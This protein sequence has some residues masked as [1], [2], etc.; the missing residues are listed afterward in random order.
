MSSLKKLLQWDEKFSREMILDEKHRLPRLFLQFISHS[1]DSWYW[2]V[3]LVLVWAFSK[4]Q[5]RQMALFLAF[6]LGLLAVFVLGVKFLVRRARP[7]GEW[8][9]IYR[10]T[11]PHS[12]PSGHAARAMA[13]A[14]ISLSLEL[15]WWIVL[16][17][18][19]WAVLVGLSRILLSLHYFSDVVVGWLI[20]LLSGWLAILLF[21][22]FVHLGN[23]IFPALF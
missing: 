13:I 19:L 4:G 3:G 18:F 23:Q 2:L 14:V 10:S 17:L 5:T 16:L 21:P 8:G 20:G 9:Q 1:C 6:G 12:F 22:V 15:A 7:E 11:D